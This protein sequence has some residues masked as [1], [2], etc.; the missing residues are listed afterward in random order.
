MQNFYKVAQS[1]NEKVPSFTMR[2]EET[3]NQIRLQCPGR[4]MDHEAQKHLKDCLFHGVCK[5][6]CGSIHYL[7]STSRT[8]YSQLMVTAHKEGSEN[9]EIWDKVRARAVVATDPGEG[10]AELEY[11]IAK[12]MVTLT[13][14][15]WATTP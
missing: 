5:H 10:I 1:N 9:E 2:L 13:K 12:V 15:E 11:Q 6:I 3:L 7:Y 4:M 8:S 14:A